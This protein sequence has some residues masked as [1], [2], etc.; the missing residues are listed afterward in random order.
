MDN[1]FSPTVR[2]QAIETTCSNLMMAGLLLPQEVAK[3]MRQIVVYNDSELAE[4]LCESRFLY[5]QHL[6]SYWSMN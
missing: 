4:V 6:E 1:L 2:D 5:D 3:Y